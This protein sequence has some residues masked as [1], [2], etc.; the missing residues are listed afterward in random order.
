MTHED[1][2]EVTQ[3]AEPKARYFVKDGDTYLAV[4]SV[5]IQGDEISDA[6]AEAGVSEGDVIL[7]IAESEMHGDG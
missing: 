2:E 7:T 1:V 4:E 3:D 6:A 5:T